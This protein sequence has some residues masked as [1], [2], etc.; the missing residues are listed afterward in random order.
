M[1]Q[2]ICTTYY[3]YIKIC[4]NIYIKTTFRCFTNGLATGF[5]LDSFML[6]KPCHISSCIL[7]SAEW[8]KELIFGRAQII[9][10]YYQETHT[11]P[12]SIN[13]GN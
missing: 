4:K 10:K 5:L 11:C 7:F 13:Q 1:K 12:S 6:I 9:N 8:Y 2:N 3:I